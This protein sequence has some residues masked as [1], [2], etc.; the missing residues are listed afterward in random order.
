MYTV[1]PIKSVDLHHLHDL[2][3][4]RK[5]SA[6]E[7]AAIYRTFS[8]RIHSYAEICQLLTVTPESHAG[9]FYLSLGLF[10]PQADVRA[11]TVE[12]LT[13]IREHLAGRHFWN[14]LSRYAKLAFF[15]QKREAERRRLDGRE[16]LGE[17]HEGLAEGASRV[18]SEE[19]RARVA[20]GS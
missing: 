7:S 1:R 11:G 4:T 18:G 9:L 19:D 3:R 13:R 8:S 16:D 12:L 14:G 15:R 2:L 5:L 6:A 10:H 20:R 17:G